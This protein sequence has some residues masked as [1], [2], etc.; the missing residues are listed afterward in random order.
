[1]T[2]VYQRYQLAAIIATLGIILAAIYMLWLYQ[3]VFTGP[4]NEKSGLIKDLDKKEVWPLVPVFALLIVFG[5]WPQPVL[6]TIEKS[7]ENVMQQVSAQDPEP[8]FAVENK[9][10]N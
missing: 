7:V 2:G 1:L 5:F 6:Q 9:E 4:E 10:Q 8:F 3:R